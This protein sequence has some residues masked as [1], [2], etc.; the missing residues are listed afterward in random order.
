MTILRIFINNEDCL[1]NKWQIINSGELSGEGESSN[2]KELL[3]FEYEFI[4]IYL[5]PYLSNV[6]KVD[7]EHISDRKISDELLM[8]LVENNIVDE[9]E[10]CK[11]ILMKLSDGESYVAVLNLVFYSSLVTNL[12]DH[13]KKVKFI[14]PMPYITDFQDGMWT[15]YID[16]DFK[17]VRTST[18]EYYLLD[19][20]DSVPTILSELFQIY[21]NKE[22]LLYCNDEKIIHEIENNFGLTC[23]LQNE[24]NYGAFIWNF[25][26]E[27]TKKFNLKLNE[28]NKRQIF[29]IIKWSSSLVAVYL[30]M[31]FIHLFYL[32][33]TKYS[34]QNEV[35]NNLT[36]IIKISDNQT[37]TLGLMNNELVG[38]YHAK[39]L[40]SQDDFM[41]LFNIFLH[42]VPEIGQNSVVGLK[43]S[44]NNLDV[45]LNSQFDK[46]NFDS[47][48][49]ILLTKRV[50]ASMVD[51]QSYQNSQQQ[52]GS[53]NNGGGVL[54]DPGD[55]KQ[56]ISDAVWVVSLKSVTNLDALNVIK[57]KIKTTK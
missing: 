27:K 44:A 12:S 9:I 38:M 39:G 3:A 4:E 32:L 53:N 46:K 47:V 40:Y 25:Y 19:D 8:G 22:I 6:F 56:Q 31:W 55:Q 26:N 54:E 42:N 41:S 23:H 49:E 5:A 37:N 45:I 13:I 21:E 16:G 18:Y 51:Y 20:S 24:L 43:Y 14:Q 10:D 11:P 30:V 2:I 35:K 7:I 36:G 57:D 17:F 52:S 48:K 1:N 28:N 50:L 33:G 34:L 29:S 15:V